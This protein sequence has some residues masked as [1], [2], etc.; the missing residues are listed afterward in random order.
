MPTN[1]LNL[2][3]LQFNLH[4][5][6]VELN[7]QLV[8]RLLKTVPAESDVIV[9]PEMFTTG[10]SMN[11]GSLSVLMGGDEVG[12]MKEWA[13]SYDKA[14]VGSLIVEEDGFY[15]NRLLWVNPDGEL[16]TYDKKHLFAHN[17]YRFLTCILPF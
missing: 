5:E 15:Y 7:M 8:E 14:I 9:L 10:F 12:R 6:D 1:N 11:A 16:F 4:W 3:V 2:S 17:R 13:R